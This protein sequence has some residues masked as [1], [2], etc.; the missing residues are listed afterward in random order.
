MRKTITTGRQ[1]TLHRSSHV[2]GNF[3]PGVELCAVA[4]KKLVPY[5]PTH[6]QVCCTRQLAQVS[7]VCCWH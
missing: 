2:L 3:W 1:I 6:V 7:G 5:W 4:C